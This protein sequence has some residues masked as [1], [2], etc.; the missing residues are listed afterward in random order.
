MTTLVFF[1]CPRKLTPDSV[2][3]CTADLFPSFSQYSLRASD[4]GAPV[5]GAEDTAVNVTKSLPSG[6]YIIVGEAKNKHVGN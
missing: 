1:E 2:L 4:K 3:G 5:Q 6:A